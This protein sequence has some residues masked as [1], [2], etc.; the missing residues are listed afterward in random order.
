MPG[1]KQRENNPPKSPGRPKGSPNKLTGQVK[2]MILAALDKAGGVDYLTAQASEN[3]SAFMTLVGKVL[4]LQLTGDA[5][6]PIQTV[7]RVEMA[8]VD[9]IT[10]D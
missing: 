4:P 6:N 9:P 1:N 5:E 2:E 7:T 8:I 10:K 3:P